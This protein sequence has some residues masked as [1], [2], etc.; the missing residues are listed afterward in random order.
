MTTV[1]RDF[2][3]RIKAGDGWL[4]GDRDNTY[5]DNPRCVQIIEYD[6]AWGGKAY[7]LVFEG[8]RNKYTPS[9]YVRNP[10]TWWEASNARG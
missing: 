4:D 5:G 7:G 3:A 10:K 8:Q 1:D 2:A 9:P 6:N